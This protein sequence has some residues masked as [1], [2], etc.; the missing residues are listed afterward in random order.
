MRCP[1]C[2]GELTPSGVIEGTWTGT[3]LEDLAYEIVATGVVCEDCGARWLSPR[4]VP[5]S[6]WKEIVKPSNLEHPLLELKELKVLEVITDPRRIAELELHFEG[7]PR[8][9][10]VSEGDWLWASRDGVRFF[11]AGRL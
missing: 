7:S 2:G 3:L 5:A 6:E 1:I 11:L 9:V 10:A 4:P 8:A